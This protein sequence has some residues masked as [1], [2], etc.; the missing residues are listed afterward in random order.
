[1][2]T[3]NYQYYVDLAEEAAVKGLKIRN[4]AYKLKNELLN[5]WP[6]KA[7]KHIV[8]TFLAME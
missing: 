5:N 2:T 4:A 8:L 7:L 6:K 3:E 1:M